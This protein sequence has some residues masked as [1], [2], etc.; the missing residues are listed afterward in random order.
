M[1]EGKVRTFALA[2]EN[3]PS[4]EGKWSS[5]AIELKQIFEQKSSKNFVSS[6]I[7][8]NFAEQFW[9]E[10]LRLNQREHWKIYNRQEVVQESL[11]M[12]LKSIHFNHKQQ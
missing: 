10:P 8:R 9:N 3:G 12:M 7:S 1:A 2:F 6:K 5:P 11:I 4:A